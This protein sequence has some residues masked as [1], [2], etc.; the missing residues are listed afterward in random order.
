M[1]TAIAVTMTID[2]AAMMAIVKESIINPTMKLPFLFSDR[3]HP[4]A[5]CRT[6]L[7]VV[8]RWLQVESLYFIGLQG[9]W[10]LIFL[11]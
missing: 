3:Q 1:K 5:M 2:M 9:R 6:E 7:C 10:R 11:T 8:R 4:T